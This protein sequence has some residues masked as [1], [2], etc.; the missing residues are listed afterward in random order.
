MGADWQPLRMLRVSLWSTADD[1][2]DWQVNASL[3]LSPD[4]LQAFARQV[5]A[6]LSTPML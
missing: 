6:E 1:A 2:S 5:L 4:Q 3:L